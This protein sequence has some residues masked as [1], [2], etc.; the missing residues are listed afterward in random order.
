MEDNNVIVDESPEEEKK[1][2]GVLEA[3]NEAAKSLV[4]SFGQ[5]MRALPTN[6]ISKHQMSK[7]GA[8]HEAGAAFKARQVLPMTPAQYRRY[9][10]GALKEKTE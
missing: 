1:T 5:Y 10:F 2:D 9:H 4:A 7:R 8:K 3:M 6:R